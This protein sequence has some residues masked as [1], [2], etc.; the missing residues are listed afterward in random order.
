MENSENITE[1]SP[2]RE[3]FCQEYIIDLNG[4]QAAIRSGYSER[5]AEVTAS[6]LLSDDK[7][8]GRISQLMEDRLE[9][10]KLTQDSVI[11]ELRKIAFSDIRDFVEWDNLGVTIKS[12]V[13][14]SASSSQ[15]VSMVSQK[16]N[17]FGDTISFKLHDK[18]KALE[19]LGN[20][21][22][23]FKSNA[24]GDGPETIAEALS[25][26]AEKLPL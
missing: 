20:H 25:K 26:L 10:T 2:K 6:R 9:R 4:K 16:A 22:G 18:V 1:V 8:K 3:R 21:L 13:G 24:S 12:S 23:M 7:V 5:S 11:S 19:L 17:K 14:I 15:C